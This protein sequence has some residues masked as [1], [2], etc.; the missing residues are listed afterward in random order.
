MYEHFVANP[1]HVH[2]HQTQPSIQHDRCKM[3]VHWVLFFVQQ[4]CTD[5]TLAVRTCMHIDPS[6]AELLTWCDIVS[7][8]VT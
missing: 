5:L 8:V 7:I 4:M 1:K 6:S 2:R 3:E